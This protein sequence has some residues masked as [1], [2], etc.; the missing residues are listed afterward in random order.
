MDRFASTASAARPA[1]QP[2][3]VTSPTP[4]TPAY[5]APAVST[6]AQAPTA[7]PAP[8]NIPTTAPAWSPGNAYSTNAIW[9]NRVATEYNPIMNDNLKANY[10]QQLAN[11][12]ANGN[13]RWVGGQFD[14]HWT[15]DPPVAPIYTNTDYNQQF[16]YANENMPGMKEYGG[17]SQSNNGFLDAYTKQDPSYWG[18]LPQFTTQNT[19][20]NPGYTSQLPNT[21]LVSTI[22][23]PGGMSP[24]ALAATGFVQ[25]GTTLQQNPIA[26]AQSG[27]AP[28][29]VT[30]NGSMSGLANMSSLMSLLALL[31]QGSPQK[32]NPFFNNQ[33]SL[34]YP[35]TSKGDS[36]TSAYNQLYG[37]AAPSQAQGSMNPIITLLAALLGGK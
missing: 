15:T 28:F 16:Q 2:S 1:Y 7:P 34:F 33:R 6:T 8:T 19:N 31:G 24:Q 21:G 29:S 32:E 14:G 10:D 3:A 22:N 27:A 36:V 5:Q 25:P 23:N 11:Y 35:N 20:L 4:A 37:G 30:G 26:A 12:A 9:A 13:K 17:T 18:T